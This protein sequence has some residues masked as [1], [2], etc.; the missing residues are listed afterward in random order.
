MEEVITILRSENERLRLENE[1][2][3]LENNQMRARIA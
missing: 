3:R 2:L 1:H